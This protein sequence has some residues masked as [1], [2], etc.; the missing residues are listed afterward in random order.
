MSNE[1][2][3]NMSVYNERMSKTMF[4]KMFFM[5]MLFNDA[6][7]IFDYGCADGSLIKTM[8]YFM[9]S[10]HYIGYDIDDAMVRLAQQN[11]PD[12]EIAST[13]DGFD[14]PKLVS[15]SVLNVS[16]VIHEVYS[17]SSKAE[18]QAFWNFMFESGFR[19][20][21]VRDMMVVESVDRKT[22][23]NNILKVRQKYDQSLISDFENNF[24]SLENNKSFVHFLLKYRYQEN[25]DREV[26]ENYLP[27]YVSEFLD[28]IPIAEYEI[29]YQ[30]IYTLPYLKQ[31][32]KS[33]FDVDLVDTTHI[34]ILLKRK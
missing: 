19:Y 10:Y 9:P 34:K 4:D 12:A 11:V 15:H 1:I 13:L 17:Y 7:T 21:A 33:D 16:S 20:I 29:L 30:D 8:Q 3:H 24:G 23:I 2:I 25:W 28:L 6:D 18:I 26:K 5:T 32:V 14:L 27:L 31:Q 22:D